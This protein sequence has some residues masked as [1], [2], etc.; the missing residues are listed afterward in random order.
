[1]GVEPTNETA[2]ISGCSRME[3]TATLSPLTTLKTPSGSPASCHNSA[4]RRETL[5]SRS[6]GLRMNVL[7]QAMGN[8]YIHIGTMLGKFTG[9]VLAHHTRGSPKEKTSTPVET[10]LEKSPLRR[11]GRP[12]ANS[13]TSSPR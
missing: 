11:V 2:A 8:G 1:M 10:W 4:T 9:V 6:L 7:P 3:S 12:Q 5:G 13:T